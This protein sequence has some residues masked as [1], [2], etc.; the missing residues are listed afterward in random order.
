MGPVNSFSQNCIWENEVLRREVR[1]GGCQAPL[2]CPVAYSG[3]AVKGAA[4]AAFI[5]VTGCGHA[6]P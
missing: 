4:S 6:D 2:I 3:G 5:G 1:R